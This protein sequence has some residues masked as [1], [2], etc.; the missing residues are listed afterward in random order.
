[1]EERVGFGA[2]KLELKPGA[3]R[4]DRLRRSRAMLSRALNL[5]TTVAFAGA[6]CSVPL[7]YPT[8]IEFAKLMVARAIE[9]CQSSSHNYGITDSSMLERFHAQLQAGSTK[10]HQIMFILGESKKVFERCDGKKKYYRFLRETFKPR[11]R[12]ADALNPYDGLLDLPIRRFITTNYDCEIEKA[13]SRI[14]KVPKNE[15]GLHRKPV[16]SSDHYRD[17]TQEHEYNDQLA[18]FALA[19]VVEAE[20]MVFHCH[21]HY[22]KPESLI[23]T[24]DDYQRWYVGQGSLGGTAFSQTISLLF[25]SNPLL[26]VGYGMGDDD[27]LGT[28]RMF[29]AVDPSRK[30]SRPLFALLPERVEGEDDDDHRFYYERYGVNV[31]PYLVPKDEDRGRALCE[32]LSSV[33]DTWIDWRNGWLQKPVIRKI[34]IEP[35]PPAPY[36]H[37]PLISEDMPDFG[38][39]R[40]RGLLEDLRQKAEQGAQLI[41]L[42]GP[43][44]TGKSWYAQQVMEMVQNKGTRF[45]GFY[46]WSSYYADDSLTGIDRALCYLGRK[47][48]KN[49]SRVER[50]QECLQE[51]SYFLV[52]DGIERF[53]RETEN[54]EEGSAFEPNTSDF[55]AAMAHKDNKSTVLL[56]SRLW[57]DVFNAKPFRKSKISRERIPLFTTADI[58]RVPPFSW[59]ENREEISALCSLLDGHIYGLV[60]AA[61]MIMQ[62][63]REGA[64]NCWQRIRRALYDTPPHARTSRMIHE[65]I[66]AV[67]ER[68]DGL[69]LKLLERLAVF[70]KPVRDLTVEICY[71]AALEGRAVA[72]PEKVGALIDVLLSSRLLHKVQAKPGKYAY[73]VHPIVRGYVYHRIHHASTDLIPNFTLPGYTAGTATVDPGNTKESARVV[74]DI[75]NKLHAAAEREIKE[76]GD[77]KEGQRNARNLCRASFGVVRSR[78]E[79]I[80]TPRWSTYDD[81]LRILIKIG[82]LAKSISPRVWDYAERHDILSVEGWEGPFYPDELAWLYNEIGLTSYSEG[83]MLDALALWEQGHEINRVIDSV[84]E[85]GRYLFQSLCNLGAAYIHYGNINTAEH[86]LRQAEQA[87]YNLKDEDHAGR[88]IGYLGLIQHLRGNL[89][90]ADERYE[91][92][93]KKLKVAR[94][95]R[96]ESIFLRHR[97]DLKIQ[98]RDYEMASGLIQTSRSLAEAE[99]YPELIAYS[100]LSQGH[101][102]RSQKEYPKALREYNSVLDEGQRI[103]MRRLEAEALTELSRLAYD[104]GDAQVARQRAIES[105]RIANDLVLGLRQT[106]DL[107]VLGL[108]TIETGQHDLGVA[109][110]LHAKKIADRQEYWLRSN[111]AEEHLQ[112]YGQAQQASK[113][114]RK[115]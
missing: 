61:R 92:A 75:F 82:N 40:V 43:G 101:L 93:L 72:K 81:Y 28:L 23:V 26:F 55:L 95:P 59:F 8:W 34:D 38:G 58:E 60:L 45:R 76:R 57:P 113:V 1:M 22:N 105:L 62:A 30:S 89:Q 3:T 66:K 47:W 108:A 112:K 111:E 4:E 80:T 10:P 42:V 74:V 110:L 50:F 52:F 25:G 103:G 87:N 102:Y 19:R 68:W 73:T 98:Q 53:L 67:D 5:R 65:S 31:I 27:L 11:Q 78:M 91:E 32:A 86:Y 39:E 94:N 54:P 41:A 106:H 49:L 77:K 18:L 24:E 96:A 56:T 17:F 79:A 104:L 29:A 2:H 15:F 84:E 6:G 12:P 9:T 7:G 97:A 83:T 21:G 44:G 115:D 13:L 85:G 71:D 107:V 48:S 20:N 16:D 14:R 114:T 100:R 109:Y 36:H 88:I 69:A 63:G 33:K 70:M 90:Q 64:H 46:F 35:K 37:Y 99:R 51:D